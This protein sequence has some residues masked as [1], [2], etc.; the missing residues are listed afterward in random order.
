VASNHRLYAVSPA[1]EVVLD[2]PWHLVDAG[3]WSHDA[4]LLTVT[5]VDRQRPAQWV[6]KEATL[7]PETLR[8]RVQASVVLAHHVDLGE[9]RRA[10]AV[11]RQDLATGELVEQVV[12][13]RNVRAAD[14]GVEE[15]TQAALAY[16]KEQV[17]LT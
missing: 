13:G 16:L 4:Y 3:S 15:Q 2:R 8:E 11:I 6:F 5:W 10:R 9:R 17:G 12:L 1:G 7:L 14:P